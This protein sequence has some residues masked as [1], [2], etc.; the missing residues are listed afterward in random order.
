MIL[1]QHL[2]VNIHRLK[3]MTK[4]A[5]SSNQRRI[6]MPNNFPSVQEV[7]KT[8]GDFILFEYEQTNCDEGGTEYKEIIPVN[9]KD[10]IKQNPKCFITNL[11]NA[12]M[13]LFTSYLDNL[14]EGFPE[15]LKRDFGAKKLNN[16]ALTES[17]VLDD[18]RKFGFNQA[19]SLC[20]SYHIKVVIQK[21]KEIE[22]LRNVAKSASNITE[23]QLYEIERLRKELENK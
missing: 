3:N 17:D 18:Y 19:L 8:I 11:A 1:R 10:F 7:E 12:I 21:D 15:E 4:P 20:K 2:L 13:P 14:A 23:K 16:E 9:L 5:P 22:E 6:I